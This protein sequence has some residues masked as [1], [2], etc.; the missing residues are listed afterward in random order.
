MRARVT[1]LFSTAA[2]ILG[3]GSQPYPQ[4]VGVL[5][6]AGAIPSIAGRDGLTAVQ[7]ATARGQSVIA[8]HAPARHSM[9]GVVVAWPG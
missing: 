4:T 1:P 6:D 8:P 9:T 7:H 5:L 3:D 2:A